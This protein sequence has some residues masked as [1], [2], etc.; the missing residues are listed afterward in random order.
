V[1]MFTER[2]REVVADNSACV[3]SYYVR[4]EQQDAAAF[5][6][7]SQRQD[8]ENVRGIV[9]PLAVTEMHARAAAIREKGGKIFF[10]AMEK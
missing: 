4:C 7:E 2:V 3:H 5:D 1:P 10:A 9:K 6:F 8:G